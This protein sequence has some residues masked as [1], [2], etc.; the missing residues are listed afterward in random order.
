[1]TDH[2]QSNNDESIL[3]FQTFLAVLKRAELSVLYTAAWSPCQARD[4]ASG[5]IKGPWAKDL[6]K[7][8]NC[9]YSSWRE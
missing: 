8:N 3:C 7:A 9:C 4:S 2:G 6:E 5:S 1:M